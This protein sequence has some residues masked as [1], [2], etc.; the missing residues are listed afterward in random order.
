MRDDIREI[1]FEGNEDRSSTFKRYASADVIGGKILES[2][3]KKTCKGE[4]RCI[5]S[6]T[7]ERGRPVS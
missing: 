1:L 4:G 5:S 2:I 6:P 3:W 7:T